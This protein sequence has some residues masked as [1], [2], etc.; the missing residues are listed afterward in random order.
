MLKD[1]NTKAKKL[2]LPEYGRHIQNMVDYCVDLKDRD[3][4][5]R[6]AEMIVNTMSSF[7]P[8]QKE[9]EDYWQVL[10]DHLYIMSG[11]KLD[12]DFPYEVS[13]AEQYNC[14]PAAHLPSHQNIPPRYRHYGH[15][16]D[17]MI[18]IVLKMPKGP[19]RDEYEKL[20]AIQMK[21]DYIVWNKNNVANT[22]IFTD[23][24]EMSKGEIYLDEFTC[25]LPDPKDLLSTGT[26]NSNSQQKKKNNNTKK[27]RK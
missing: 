11:F 8:N 14:R 22:R 24:F 9:R 13:T 20:I 16:I 7:F 5:K 15:S 19:E 26:P 27:K 6:C 23:L 10:W 2:Q 25:G 17:K 3:E 1:Y 4:R 18:D 12:I 21:R